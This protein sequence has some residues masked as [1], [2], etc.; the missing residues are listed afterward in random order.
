MYKCEEC[1]GA[2]GKIY[3]V[4]VANEAI[5]VNGRDATTGL[6]NGLDT[7]YITIKFY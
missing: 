7:F 5:I 4:Q 2:R 6:E 3:I 1:N